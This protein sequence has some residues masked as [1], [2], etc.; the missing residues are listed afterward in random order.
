[1]ILPKKEEKVCLDQS[2]NLENE[3]RDEILGHQ[4]N[5]KLEF[6][7]HAIHSP[8]YLRDFNDPYKKSAKQENSSLFMNNLL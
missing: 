5:K 2:R 8:F 7:L 6:L 3:C 1:M 4:F